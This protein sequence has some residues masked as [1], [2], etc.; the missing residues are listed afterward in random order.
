MPAYIKNS[1]HLEFVSDRVLTET[2][3][4]TLKSMIALQV[5]EPQ[6]LEGNQ[7]T[8]TAQDIV[9]A[10]SVIVREGN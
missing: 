7:E 5:E 3:L 1:I 6:D 8:W 4:D 2:E 10:H 9:T